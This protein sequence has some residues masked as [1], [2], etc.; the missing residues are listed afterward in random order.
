MMDKIQEQILQRVKS[1][2]FNSIAFEKREMT[3]LYIDEH[4]YKEGEII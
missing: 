1:H 2:A 3:N 4:A